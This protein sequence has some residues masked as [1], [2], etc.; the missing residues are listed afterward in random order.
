MK[1][2][3]T[4]GELAMEIERQ[5]ASK[6]DFVA[7]TSTLQVKASEP[8][9]AVMV[10]NGHGEFPIN[11]I[12]QDQ[13]AEHT[14]IPAKYAKRLLAEAPELYAQNVNTWLGKA[15]TTEKRLA[16]T[17]DGKLRS[18]HSERFATYDNYDMM[19]AALPIIG[20]RGLEIM[21]CELTDKRLYLK[22]VDKQLF[23]DVPVGHKMGDGTHTIFDTVAPALILG[24]SEVGFGRY[25]METGAYTRACTNM[26]LFAKG[27]FK[28]THLG[29]AQGLSTGLDVEEL[30]AALSSATKRKMMEAVVLQT[31]DMIAAAFDPATFEKRC[32]RLAAAAGNVLPAGK[33]EGIQ[34]VLQE[35]FSLSENE[36]SN[37]FRHLI[38]GGQLS[39][40][41]L[42][43][44]IT[45]AAQDAD[46]YDRAT[47][48]E[49]LGGRVVELNRSEWQALAA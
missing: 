5:A 46:D 20:Q 16:R 49:Y 6:R 19:V 34:E 31:R 18:L 22:A 27:G 36:S 26:A 25:F 37:V 2:G 11:P 14:G 33:V 23:K 48:L 13:L 9:T 1:T 12:A 24:N 17:L 47:E 40:Y 8:G 29:A 21:S 10:L 15:G 38:E 39:Q 42:H 28:K 4:L 44:A 30:D 32:E 7:A 43:S 45:R 35:R 41:G 3:K